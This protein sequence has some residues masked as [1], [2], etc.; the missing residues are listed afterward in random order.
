MV[1]HVYMRDV[2]GWHSTPPFD[3]RFRGGRARNYRASL[4]SGCE[5]MVFSSSFL[6]FFLF[7][8]P[9][10]TPPPPE[11]RAMI[12][13]GQSERTWAGCWLP[14]PLWPGSTESINSL[15]P[16]KP[17][18]DLDVR[19]NGDRNENYAFEFTTARNLESSPLPREQGFAGAALPTLESAIERKDHTSPSSPYMH[20]GNH[21]YAQLIK[22]T[23]SD[24]CT[25]LANPPRSSASSPVQLS[26]S[27]G[28]RSIEIEDARE[29]KSNVFSSLC[30]FFF[31]FL[32]FF[33]FFFRFFG[34]V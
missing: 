11:L 8:T 31:F 30:V 4:S 3:Y 6:S 24:T 29:K 15:K 18:P 7:S 34:F 12:K 13:V 25:H 32:F 1:N 27:T 19:T 2:A 22:Y 21:A 10:P 20:Q 5:W 16:E 26:I 17:P 28:R 33:R 9:P 14:S 23:T